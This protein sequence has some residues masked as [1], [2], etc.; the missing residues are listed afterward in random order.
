MSLYRAIG[1]PDLLFFYLFPFLMNT[2]AFSHYFQ[3]YL[4]IFLAFLSKLFHIFLLFSIS[5]TFVCRISAIIVACSRH[6]AHFLT[7]IGMQI[8]STLHKK[9]KLS[10]ISSCQKVSLSFT[11]HNFSFFCKVLTDLYSTFLLPDSQTLTFP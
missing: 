1:V 2:W 7:I 11:C 6:I 8:N 9:K 10:N 3:A 4:D 5:Q